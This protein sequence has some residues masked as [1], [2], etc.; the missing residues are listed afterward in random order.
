MIDLNKLILFIINIIHILVILF[1]VL[2]PF[3]DNDFM[4]MIHT[5]IIP[6]IMVHWLLNNDTCAITLA[7]QYV[8]V[9]MNGGNPVED[10]ECIA[11]KVIGPVYTFMNDYAD[12]STWSWTLTTCLWM[13]SSFKVVNKFKK[14]ELN[15]YFVKK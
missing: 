5:L 10:K 11:Y 6:F 8:R 3:T 2:V 1:V 12:Y 7:E 4:L 14:G 9:Q 13:I 15:K